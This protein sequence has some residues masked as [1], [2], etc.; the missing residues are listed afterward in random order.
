LQHQS[1]CWCR[2]AELL[3]TLLEKEVLSC[4]LYL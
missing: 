2:L 1:C 3:I 4:L